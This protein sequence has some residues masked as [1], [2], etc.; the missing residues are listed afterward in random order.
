MFDRERFSWNRLVDTTA[1]S[2]LGLFIL[3]VASLSV[4]AESA[5]CQKVTYG[6][7]EYTVC[8]V[9]LHRQSVRLFWKKTDGRPYGYPSSL[10]PMI[11]NHRLLFATNGGMYNPDNSPVGLYVE[12]GRELARVN[13]NAGPGNFHM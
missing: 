2:A 11:G 8:E 1:K 7:S 9:D 3:L 12:H 6:R 10:P 5:P 4:R 13:T